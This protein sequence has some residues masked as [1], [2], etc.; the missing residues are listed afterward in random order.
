MAKVKSQRAY[1]GIM[2]ASALSMLLTLGGG[3]S[4]S[5]LHAAAQRTQAVES[6][7]MDT[8]HRFHVVE[9]TDPPAVIPCTTGKAIIAIAVVTG[10]QGDTEDTQCFCG[11]QEVA[12]AKAT[13]TTPATDGLYYGVSAG[14]GIQQ[15][16]GGRSGVLTPSNP[17]MYFYGQCVYE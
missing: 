3:M 16:S 9:P 13:A 10:H 14:H 6:G 11:A 1:W 17:N 4:Y 7:N 8:G 2:G 15:G 12:N 5:E